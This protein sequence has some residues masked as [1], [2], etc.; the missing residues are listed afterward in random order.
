LGTSVSHRLSIYQNVALDL[1]NRS[2]EIS[3][4]SDTK[5]L[6]WKERHYDHL[7]HGDKQSGEAVLIAI[8]KLRSCVLKKEFMY[9]PLD[10]VFYETRTVPQPKKRS[11]YIYIY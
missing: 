8:A 5:L 1:L 10:G 9:V 6:R 11:I 4:A 7:Y 2:S 3:V